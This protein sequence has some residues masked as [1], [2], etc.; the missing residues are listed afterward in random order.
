MSLLPPSLKTALSNFKSCAQ[1]AP[2]GCYDNAKEL[3]EVIGTACDDLMAAVRG[4]GLKAD[5]CDLIFE[6]EAAMY[7]YIK[8]SNPLEGVLFATAEGFGASLEGPARDRVIMQ[9]ERNRDFL[10]Q[11]AG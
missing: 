2:V 4:L 7:D 10:K 11:F 6:L 9:A 3:H 1:D 8:R 5:N